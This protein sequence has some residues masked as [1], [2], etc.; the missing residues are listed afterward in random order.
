MKSSLLILVLSIAIFTIIINCTS[1]SARRDIQDKTESVERSE[2]PEVEDSFAIDSYAG[3]SGGSATNLSRSVYLQ[4]VR[5][6][7]ISECKESCLNKGFSFDECTNKIDVNMV[8]LTNG[9]ESQA[10]DAMNSL[11]KICPKEAARLN[12]NLNKI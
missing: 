10:A 9:D 6:K 7:F 11:L 4:K 5:S 1:T 3:N 2:L 8:G 12:Q